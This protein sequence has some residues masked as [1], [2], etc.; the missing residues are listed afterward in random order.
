M[1]SQRTNNE[2][3]TRRVSNNANACCDASNNEKLEMLMLGLL[4]ELL[5]KK[6]GVMPL[7]RLPAKRAVVKD[8]ANLP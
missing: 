5:A 6:A 7:L 3:H 8:L 2:Y 4:V 1:N